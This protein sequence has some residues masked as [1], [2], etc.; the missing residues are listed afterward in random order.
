MEGGEYCS[1][2]HGADGAWSAMVA[3]VRCLARQ[4]AREAWERGSDDSGYPV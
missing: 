2:P 3:L 1:D 4:A